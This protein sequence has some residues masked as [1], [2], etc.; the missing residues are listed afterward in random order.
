MARFGG[1]TSFD[2][3]RPETTAERYALEPSMETRECDGPGAMARLGQIKASARAKPV[4]LPFTPLRDR[5]SC[6][7]LRAPRR[8]RRP[9]QAARQGQE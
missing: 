8:R 3:M 9:R 4:P 7:L 1:E 5:N 2:L 6:P